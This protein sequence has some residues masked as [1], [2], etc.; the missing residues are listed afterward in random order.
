MP[1]VALRC[2]RPNQLR[3]HIFAKGSQGLSHVRRN[4]KLSPST[5]E[6]WN[7][8]SQTRLSYSMNGRGS[9][10]TSR[11]LWRADTGMPIDPSIQ[12]RGR[13]VVRTLSI[14]SGLRGTCKAVLFAAPARIQSSCDFRPIRVTC[15]RTMSR[16]RRGTGA[17]FKCRWRTVASHTGQPTPDSDVHHT[18]AFSARDAKGFLEQISFFDKTRKK[19]PRA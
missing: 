19:P 2:L 9:C 14:A 8:P 16:V 3:S 6:P 17:D 5:A 13:G 11:E 4:Q 10:S 7:I 12:N 18:N 1:R 15:L